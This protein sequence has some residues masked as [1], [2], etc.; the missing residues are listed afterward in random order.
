MSTFAVVG[1][2]YSTSSKR[3]KGS[4]THPLRH[5]RILER[6]QVGGGQHAAAHVAAIRGE[7]GSA[8]DGGCEI[9]GL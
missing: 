6:L 3:N 5:G 4:G 7:D 2:V 8:R 1:H 9:D